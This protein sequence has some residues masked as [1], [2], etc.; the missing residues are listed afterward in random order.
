MALVLSN[1]ENIDL[2]LFWLKLAV[3]ICCVAIAALVLFWLRLKK[4][5]KRI[6]SQKISTKF[7]QRNLSRHPHRLLKLPHQKTVPHRRSGY[8][9]PLPY[10]RSLWRW[11]LAIASIAG[12]AI[13]LGNGFIGSEVTTFL[14][15][16]IGVMLVAV[17]T[18]DI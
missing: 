3:G 14:W 10:S 15:L 13:A 11:L 7:A 12:V 4:L 18:I 9:Q 17:A 2:L 6:A 5:E 1:Q 8:K 16:L